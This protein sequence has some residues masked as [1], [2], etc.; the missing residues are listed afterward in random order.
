MA[1]GQS[2]TV[3]QDARDRLGC[4]LIKGEEMVFEFNKTPAPVVLGCAVCGGLVSLTPS[5]AAKFKEAV[6]VHPSGRYICKFCIRAA[7]YET[8]S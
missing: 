4:I 2:E 3:Y 7:G 8:G 1:C 6:R 5:E